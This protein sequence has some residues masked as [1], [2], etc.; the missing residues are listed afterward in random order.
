MAELKRKIT[1]TLEFPTEI[2]HVFGPE[3][4]HPKHHSLEEPRREPLWAG[5]TWSLPKPQVRITPPDPAI[6][7]AAIPH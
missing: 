4:P 6:L 7:R 5:I 2:R 1:K 3:A